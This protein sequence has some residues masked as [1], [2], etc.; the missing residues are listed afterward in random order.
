M[1]DC[2]YNVGCDVTA[3][4]AVITVTS[5]HIVYMATNKIFPKN[6]YNNVICSLSVHFKQL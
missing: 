1:G 5:Q 4:R 3:M 2:I 6:S